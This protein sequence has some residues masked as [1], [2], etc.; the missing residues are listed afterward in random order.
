MQEESIFVGIPSYRDS[1]CQHTVSSLFNNA[2]H[3]ERIFV[4]ICF[5]YS[6]EIDTD[7]F[8]HFPK[9]FENQVFLHSIRILL[10]FI[11]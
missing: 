3:P 5:Q 2:A 6:K 7:F 11:N 10:L 8:E 9:Q 4:G 1:E